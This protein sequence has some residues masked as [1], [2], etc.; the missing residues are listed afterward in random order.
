MGDLNRILSPQNQ[1]VIIF[2]NEKKF[3]SFGLFVANL[4][5]V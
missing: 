1:V 3:C 5:G 2:N 4:L